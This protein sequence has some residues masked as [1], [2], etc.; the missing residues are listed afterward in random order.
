MT[1]SVYKDYCAKLYDASHIIAIAPPDEGGAGIYYCSGGVVLDQDD[2]DEL[3]ADEMTDTRGKFPA[4]ED[5]NNKTKDIEY[6][7]QDDRSS[8]DYDNAAWNERLSKLKK[9][10]SAVCYERQRR[11]DGDYE[12]VGYYTIAKSGPHGKSIQIMII[13]KDMENE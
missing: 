10:Y 5:C 3:T 6:T 13:P 7:Y 1:D 4:M 11:V 8:G 2:E 9:D 12:Y